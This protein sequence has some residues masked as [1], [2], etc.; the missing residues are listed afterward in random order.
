MRDFKKMGISAVLAFCL[1]LTGCSGNGKTEYVEPAYNTEHTSVNFNDLTYARPDTDA[2]DVMIADA[3]AMI[4]E[5]GKDE[6]LLNSYQA[7]LD[8][9]AN[10]DTMQTL[11]SIHSDMDVKNEFYSNEDELLSNYYTKLDN[12]MLDLTKA[13]L[14]SDYAAA[15]KEKKGDA[16]IKRYEFNSKLNSPEVEELSEQETALVNEYKKASVDRYTTTYNGKEVTIDDLDFTDPNV[17]TPY[18]EIYEKKNAIT[19]EIYRKLVQ[20]RV[21]IAKKLG[22][23][24]YTEYAYACLGYDFTP[25]D[26]ANL[27]KYVKE[28]IAPLYQQI[29]NAYSDKIAN[30]KSDSTA[31]FEDGIPTLEKAIKAEF[32]EYMLTALNYMKD[33]NMYLYTD[34][35]NASQGAYTT[36]LNGYSAPFMFINTNNYTDPSTVFHEFGH[37]YNFF[38]YAKTLWNDGNDLNLAEIHSQGLEVLMYPYYEDLYG[39]NAKLMEYDSLNGMLSSIIQGCAEDE[40]Q[41]KVFENPD[42]TLE[43][44]NQLHG[45]IYSKYMGYP[46]YYE[47]VDIHHHYETPFYYISYATSAVSALE[48]WS[49]SVKDRAEALDIYDKITKYPEN[50]HYLEALENVSLSNPFK[51]NIMK[52]I[53]SALKKEMGL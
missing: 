48:L 25:K 7:I 30:A 29:T 4:E 35:A 46:I 11:A 10:F 38:H 47:W 53:A 39:N 33:N 13:I 34:H 50:S 17:A 16:F 31:T 40:F 1:L 21:Q 26:A 51:T 8:A 5:K 41:Q 36:L 22:Y 42:M 2:I 3:K 15:F 43:E 32:P 12:K 24:S 20:I 45:D 19:G 9:I 27:Q 18:Y 28:N 49:I 23:D 14:D 44:M 52:D 6:E 37:Y